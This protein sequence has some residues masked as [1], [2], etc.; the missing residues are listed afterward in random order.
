[1]P[2]RDWVTRRTW[3]KLLGGTVAGAASAGP[4]TG[5]PK[6]V[7]ELVRLPQDRLEIGRAAL[8]LARQVYPRVDVVDLVGLLKSYA[9]RVNLYLS[10]RPDP[11]AQ[12]RALNT[13]LFREEGYR[14]DRR[15]FARSL[16]S[17]N[18]L[19]GIL[20]AKTGIC[21]SL[22]LLYISVAQYAGIPVFSVTAPDHAFARHG[23]PEASFPNIEC[24]SGGKYFPNA[25]YIRH[26][27]VS[28]KGME[29]G[30]YMRSLSMREYLGDLLHVNA[31]SCFS[32]GRSQDGLNYLFAA[33]ELN[34]RNAPAHRD[35][36]EVL[37]RFS[38]SPGE[39]SKLL[40]EQAAHYRSRS[41]ALGYVPPEKVFEARKI[42]GI[43]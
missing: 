9:G 2:S 16:E 40:M 5:L 23:S 30:A 17:H 33:I 43:E 10:S 19:S 4:P 14:Y 7:D 12:I 41:E 34:P 31:G 13:V 35:M 36:A 25:H 24:T 26:F 15:P 18:F 28:E 21:M 6:A 39:D 11:E 1:M 32:R 22:P 37:D 38:K 8:V 3:F 42:R 20:E 29:S 27:V